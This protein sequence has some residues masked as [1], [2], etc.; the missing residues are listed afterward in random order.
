MKR[1]AIAAL[2]AWSSIALADDAAAP[3]PKEGH[4]VRVEHRDPAA[5]PARGPVDAPVTIELFFVPQVSMSMTRVQAFKLLE[6]LQAKHPTR[7]R[8]VWRV[9]RQGMIST[10]ALEAQAQGKFFEF[11]DRIFAERNSLSKDGLF[12]LAASLGLDTE[13]VA[14]AIQQDRYAQT[15]SDNDR[16]SKRLHLT[17]NP[18]VLFN[19]SPSRASFI[20]SNV[21]LADLEKSYDEAYARAQDLLEQ[22]VPASELSATFDEKVLASVTPPLPSG[23]DDEDTHDQMLASPPIGT[24]GLPSV[25]DDDAT[26]PIIFLCSPNNTGCQRMIDRALAIQKDIYPDLRLVWGPWFDVGRDDNAELAMFG[27]AALC[28]EQLGSGSPPRSSGWLWVETMTKQLGQSR[29]GRVEPEKRVD[30]I[31]KELEVDTRRLAA[32]QAVMAGTTLK[33]I[34]KARDSGVRVSPSVI[35]GGRIYAGLNDANQLQTLIEAELAPGLSDS[36]REHLGYWPH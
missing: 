31:A 7:V 19:S 33:F 14:A 22:G 8:L 18:A 6:Q 17:V 11:L 10:A 29:R 2:V 21:Q 16:R 36:L 28:A 4:I 15:F 24:A 30:A 13:R 9:L 34:E 1:L 3:P 12:K 25:G 20:S 5:A 26:M 32:C 23:G 27:D 35:V